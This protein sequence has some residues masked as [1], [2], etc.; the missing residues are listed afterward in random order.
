[1]TS[2][3]VL[4]VKLAPE[5]G[6]KLKFHVHDEISKIYAEF[7]TMNAGLG[8]RGPVKG[9]KQH[10]QCQLCAKR[11]KKEKLNE[12]HILFECEQLRRLQ[13]RYG[14][15]AYKQAAGQIDISQIYKNYWLDDLPSGVIL[16]RVESADAIRNVYINV[17]KTILRT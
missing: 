15:I 4:P 11:N 3:Y 2:C 12:Q 9:F 14:L 17:M 16:G 5:D 7:I 8:N 6:L 13:H 10:K 1:M